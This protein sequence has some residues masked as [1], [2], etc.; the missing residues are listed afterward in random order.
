MA[1]A[2][3]IRTALLPIIPHESNYYMVAFIAMFY[4]SFSYQALLAPH[5]FR[6][7]FLAALIFQGAGALAYLVMPALG[8]F[9]YETGVTPTQTMAQQGMLD[10]YRDLVAGGPAWVAEN[11]DANITAG[12]A[13]MPS[14]H[15]GGSFLFLLFAW[16]HARVLMPLYCLLFG[17]IL[18]TSIASRWHYLIDLPVGL[19]LAWFSAWSADRLIAW[20][21]RGAKTTEAAPAS[22]P[23][24]PLIT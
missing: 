4:A 5:K 23:D 17:F 16:R 10:V 8:P 18:V 6:A 15:T 12:L 1:G 14:L 24:A 22:N 3:A 13:A 2:I 11:G 7:L 21:D 20:Q 19:A 9:I